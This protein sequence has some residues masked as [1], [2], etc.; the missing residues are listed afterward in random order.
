MKIE[1]LFFGMSRDLAGKG[2]TSFE[3]VSQTDVQRLKQILLDKFPLFSKMEAFAIAINESY[4][5]DEVLL[6][7]GD[8]VAIIPPVSGG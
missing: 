4:A 2:S 3:V 8:V 7:E 1:V 6:S 5:E